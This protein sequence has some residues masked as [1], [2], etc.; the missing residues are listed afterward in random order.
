MSIRKT[1][2]VITELSN[3][4]SGTK[5][6]TAMTLQQF[7][8][9]S[10]VTTNNSDE[11]QE[12]K[13]GGVNATPF[14]GAEL[15]SY[16]DRILDKK[17][18]KQD[19]F[20][21]PYIHAGNIPVVN[22]EGQKYD[23]AQLISAVSARPAKILKQNEKM[24][25]S[26]GT[27]SVFFN[28]G[29]P[30]LKGLAVDEDKNELVIV[31]TCPGA[32]ACKTYCYAM[33]GGYV[34][35]KATSMSQS[36]ILNFLYNDPDGFF[37]QMSAEVSAALKKFGKKDTKV[38]IRWHDAGDFFSPQ[39]LSLAFSLASSFPDVDFYAYTKLADV[40]QAKKPDNFKIN[41]S[42]GAVTAQEKRIDFQKIKHSKVIPRELF[43]D[44][45]A[46]ED[47]K[48]KKDEKG[49]MQF[50][51]PTDMQAF[52]ARMSAKYSIDPKSILTYDQLMS[53]PV[54]AD[55]HKWN[56]I[57]MPGDGDDSANRNDVLGSYL[58]FH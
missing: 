23:I 17:K 14:K 37:K 13:I 49:R 28:I 54:S 51:S 38:V 41:F 36:R 27:S 39:Y 48:L 16:L 46:K 5:T 58:L 7:I 35:W 9:S 12:A 53:T 42:M 22:D 57:V 21:K 11:V 31:D 10:K 30:A 44:L 50:S 43:Y 15:D 29:L 1:L 24:Q 20:Q 18:E 32:G 8:D 45:V 4:N 25:H 55:K 56:V 2:D 19:K 40:A 33:K 26:D 34:Q 47:G 3:P 6:L 52:K